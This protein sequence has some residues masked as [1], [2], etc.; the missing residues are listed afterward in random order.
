VG[1]LSVIGCAA[2]PRRWA[3]AD[4]M[5]ARSRR[6]RNRGEHRDRNFYSGRHVWSVLRVATQAFLGR[7]RWPL[8]RF[9]CRGS[10][11]A[12]VRPW[13]PASLEC[14]GDPE[15]QAGLARSAAPVAL[16]LRGE[17]ERA[18]DPA[19]LERPGH[20]LAPPGQ[21]NGMRR[22]QR[23]DWA[24]PACGASHVPFRFVPIGFGASPA[25]SLT[26]IP[27]SASPHSAPGPRVCPFPSLTKRRA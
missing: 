9:S 3:S 18:A 15:L 17:P 20:Y 27:Q 25:Q 8:A 5:F 2:R 4:H 16:A 13:A 22:G 7:W 14:L 6:R 24:A 11:R 1:V 23:P 19:G 21:A 12:P 26:W 10:R